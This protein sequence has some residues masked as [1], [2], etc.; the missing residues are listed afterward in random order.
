MEFDPV[1]KDLG[2]FGLG[3]EIGERGFGVEF[4]RYCLGEHRIGFRSAHR[5]RGSR[6]LFGKE[7]NQPGLVDIGEEGGEG[8][9]VLGR[10]RIVFVIVATRALHGEAEKGG[11]KGVGAVGDVFDAVFFEHDSTFH[12]VTVKTV[13]SGGQHFGRTS[14]GEQIPGNLQR[15]ELVVGHVLVERRDDPVTPRPDKA[16]TVALVTVGVGVAG[17]VEPFSSHALGVSGGA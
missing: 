7:G 9:V 11:A 2:L 8:V 1:G 10:E 3:P 16:F 14:V 12:H 13:E 17:D 6:G 5:H 15:H 4:F